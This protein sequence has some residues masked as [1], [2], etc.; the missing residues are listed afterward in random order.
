MPFDK[1][2]RKKQQNSLVNAYTVGMGLFTSKLKYV[3]LKII[4]GDFK[5][6]M[7]QAGEEKMEDQ[8][9]I[10]GTFKI[11][12][13]SVYC[14]WCGK[15]IPMDALYCEFCGKY[16]PDEDEPEQKGRIDE[17]GGWETGQAYTGGGHT[18]KTPGAA[19][20][21]TIRANSTVHK[22][23]IV[24]GAF[25]VFII[26]IIMF[27]VMGSRTAEK[28]K[29]RAAVFYIKDNSLYGIEGDGGHSPQSDEGVRAEYSSSYLAKW[30]ERTNGAIL[31]GRG[32]Q[33]ERTGG[34]APAY[35]KSGQY[36]FYMEQGET[37]G[38]DLS[39]TRLKN[40]ET[41]TLDSG[42]LEFLP[43]DKEQVVYKKENQALYYYDGTRKSRLSQNASYYLV[44]QS[45]NALLWTTEE[46]GTKDIYY[47]NLSEDNER[48]RLER[49][50]ELLSAS[51][52]LDVFL[53][54]KE[55]TV[56]KLDLKGKSEALAEEVSSIIWADVFS[57]SFYF[58]R[59]A[60]S[61]LAAPYKELY[62]YAHGKTELLDDSLDEILWQQDGVI[63]YTRTGEGKDCVIAADG[64]KGEIGREVVLPEQTKL[65]GGQLYFLSPDEMGTNGSTEYE[66]CYVNISGATPGR[67]ETVDRKV[68]EIA[69][70]FGKQAYYFKNSSEGI[71]DL[72]CGGELRA[73]DVASGTVVGIP[74]SG[75]VLCIADSSSSKK[76]GTLTVLGAGESKDIADNVYGYSAVS[77]QEI[78]ILS[79][80]NRDKGRGDLLFYNGQNIVT[81]ENDIWG[82]YGI[83]SSGFCR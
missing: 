17:T 39:R 10:E 70:V 64:K 67:V 32:L 57:D 45:E 44:S 68:S 73:Y 62:Y 36:L 20:L 26:F 63:L 8:N 31:K 79:E 34:T 66:L 21:Q 77:E 75:R 80:Y 41:K 65:D 78:L 24:F 58:M 9:D 22:K 50:A 23:Y 13:G 14:P 7:M 38:F 42:V 33:G 18:G 1:K 28:D 49:N 5:N 72:Y 37:G 81:I 55:N 16:V 2:I 69:C 27:T 6:F 12:E 74:E 83:G 76:R 53:V 51:P 60:E 25:T 40:Q 59:N 82:Y 46:E 47:Q 56:Y 48:I 15:Q 54:L 61:A 11:R 43:M 71:G 19:I 29:E 30:G 52:N 4:L 35:S 3:R